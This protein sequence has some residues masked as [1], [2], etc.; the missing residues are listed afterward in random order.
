VRA[1]SDSAIEAIRTQFVQNQIF[2][3]FKKIKKTLFPTLFLLFAGFL[4]Q[5]LQ[6]QDANEKYVANFRKAM[7]NLDSSW[8]NTAKMRETTNQF[9]RLANF[10]K[11]DWLPRYYHAL[12]LV[13]LSWSADAAE[14]ETMLKAAEASVKAAD[15]ISKDN[16]EIVTLEGYL[17]Q[18]MIMINPMS[19]GAIYGPKSAATLQRA[20]TLD[21]NNPRAPYLLGQNIYFT[22]EQWGG[23]MDRAR[24]HL[25]KAAQLFATFKPASEFHPNW[26]EIV[27]KMILEGKIGKN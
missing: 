10:K 7:L 23:G 9:E 13:Q 14:R 4:A 15:G 26:G 2:I 17:Y 21:P 20:M 5:P 18:A 19:N 24:P 11:D 25:E 1:L 27:C 3:K 16:A 12:C 6:A 8:E 22:P